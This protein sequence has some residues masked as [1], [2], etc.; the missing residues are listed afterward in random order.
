VAVPR[1]VTPGYPARR[2]YPGRLVAVEGVDGSGKSTQVR[3][4]LQWLQAG[5]H[6][7]FLTA[8][9]SSPLVHPSLRRAKR[10]EALV[11]EVFCLMHAADLADRLDREV[12]PR[13]EAGFTVL[14]D[15]WV[16]TALARD[17]ARGLPARW[18]RQVYAFAPRPTLTLYF[19]V[20]VEEASARILAA[21]QRLKYYEAGLDLGLAADPA[22]SFLLFQRR[23]ADRYERLVRRERLVVVDARDP[24]PVQQERVRAL[25]GEVLAAPAGAARP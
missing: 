23:V 11:P 24:I 8:W 19:R 1:R 16:C 18:V 2:T 3:L 6:P 15:R 14:A 20:P 10:A 25:V 17:G 22:T 7:A 13:L 12:L 4:L 21:R 9:N 5:G